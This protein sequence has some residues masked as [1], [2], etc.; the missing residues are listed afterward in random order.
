VWRK[1]VLRRFKYTEELRLKKRLYGLFKKREVKKKRIFQMRLFGRKA[2]MRLY[3]GLTLA[4][5]SKLYTSIK[6]NIPKHVTFFMNLLSRVDI[7]LFV[8]RFT[9]SVFVSKEAIK[10]NLVCRSGKRF[11]WGSFDV[12]R[13]PETQIKTNDILHFNLRQSELFFVLQFYVT[14][15]KKNFIFLTACFVISRKAVVALLLPLTTI[16]SMFNSKIKSRNGS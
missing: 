16:E 2:L 7:A 8:C 12:I 10:S 15:F 11:M 14:V 6:V 13:H 5:F 3:G 4:E 1:K 9:P